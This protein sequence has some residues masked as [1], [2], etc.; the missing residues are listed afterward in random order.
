MTL[1]QVVAVVPGS[2]AALA[3]LIIGDEIAAINGVAPRD[4]IEYRLL[5]DDA[6]PELDLRRGGMDLTLTA[7]KGAGVPLG[8]EVSSAVFDRVRTCDNHCE[9][10]FIYQRSEEHTSALQ[11]PCN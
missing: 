1:P 9:F 5:T 6:D 4:V 3:G 7:A 8:I 11:S 10:C 2:P